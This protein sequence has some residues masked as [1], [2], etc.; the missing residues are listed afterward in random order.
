MRAL[1][2][3]RAQPIMQ[4]GA[5]CQCVD[6]GD[7]LFAIRR[8][9]E[10]LLRREAEAWA[11]YERHRSDVAEGAALQHL[12]G[13]L[14]PDQQHRSLRWRVGDQ[15]FELDGLLIVDRYAITIEVKAGGL[16]EPARRAA[17]DRL[18]RDLEDLIASAHH[19]ARRA[20]DALLTPETQFRDHKGSRVNIEASRIEAVLPL[21][22][23]LEELGVSPVVWHLA[24]TG[25]LDSGE[26]HP[27]TMSLYDLELVVDLFDRPS[28]LLHYLARRQTFNQI[29]GMVAIEEADLVM[30][31]LTQGLYVEGDEGPPVTFLPSLTDPIDAY[32][33]H[34]HG[35]RKTSA[36]KPAPRL[37]RELD[38]VIHFLEEQRPSGWSSTVSFLLDMH[39][40]DQNALGRRIAK[41]RR[42]SR[43]LGKPHDQSLTLANPSRGL[44]L[45]TIPDDDLDQLREYVQVLSLKNKYINKSESW[46]GIGIFAHHSEPFHVFMSWSH[47]WR[48]DP[49]LDELAAAFKQEERAKRG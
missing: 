36:K 29:G 5:T 22:I 20:R 23:T 34:K 44:T 21:T 46:S 47:P 42:L 2:A 37:H 18:R 13:V 31:Y 7:L 6:G 16:T 25:F 49:E 8:G 10:L 9:L 30:Y 48:P 43:R 11:R 39:G 4:D 17:P 26:E 1:Q 35:K 33:L 12:A 15:E 28:I 41:M 14:K 3:V 32:Y 45:V 27:T 38:S 40:D 24:R 19:Q